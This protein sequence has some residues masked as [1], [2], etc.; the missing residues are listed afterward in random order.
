VTERSF[1]LDAS[2]VMAWCF[3]DEASAYADS[4]LA[5]LARVEAIAPSVWPLEVGNVLVAAERRRRITATDAGRFAELLAR[6]PIRIVPDAPDHVLG[7]VVALARDHGLSVYDASYL[8]LA[9]REARPLASLDR[10]L[11]AAAAASGVPRWTP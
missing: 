7:P 8:D 2:V 3:E 9:L 11:L 4:A 1:V 6:L 10:R 5:E